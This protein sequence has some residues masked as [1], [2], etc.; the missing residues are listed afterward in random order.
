MAGIMLESNI[1]EGNQAAPNTEQEKEAL[2]YG[3][4]AHYIVIETLLVL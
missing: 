3:V 2:A 1:H 4:S